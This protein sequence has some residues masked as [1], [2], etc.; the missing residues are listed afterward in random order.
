MN[1]MKQKKISVIPVILIS[2][3][4]LML[5]LSACGIRM[6]LGSN[7]VIR[8]Y[9]EFADG[10]H[11]GMYDPVT[12]D[13]GFPDEEYDATTAMVINWH[14]LPEKNPELDARLAYRKIYPRN[15]V[16]QEAN[17]TSK[18]FWHREELVNRVIL[19]DLEPNSVYEFKVREEGKAFR[20]RTM[21]SSLEER[22]VKIVMTADHQTPGWG[23]TA[24]DNAKMAALQEPDM[25][26]VAGDFVND[27]GQVTAES[28]ENWATY[29]D[30]LYGAGEGYFHIDVEID[31]TLFENMII[32]HVS[33]PGNH[34]TGDEHH[35]RWPADLY[36]P[37]PGYPQFVSANWMEL[38]FH[39]PYSSQGFYSEFRPDHPNIN[40]EQ[41]QE[42]FGHG[43]FGKLS[44]SDYF[45]LIG[46]DNSQN[47]EGEPEKGL[48]DSE[49]NLITDR[50]PWFETHH[51]DVRQDLWLENLLE[52][53]SGVSAAERYT[54]I[55][56]LWHRG[57]FGTVRQNM[58]FKNRPLL[59]YWLP[60]LY[61]NGVKLIKEGHDHNYTRT[62]PM[63]IT[64]EQPEQTDVRKTNYRPATWDLPDGT[65][66]EY[67]DRFY[68]VNTLHG[69][70]GGEIIGW[71]YDN[72]Y[73]TRGEEG[74]IVVGHGGWSAS[75]RDPGNRGGGNAGLWYVDPS[76]GGETYG[77]S[78]S[79]HIH[80]VHLTPDEL[81][82]EMFRPDQLPAFE[83]GEDP[84]AIHRFKWDLSRKG[85][86]VYQPEIMEWVPYGGIAE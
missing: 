61:R 57:L 50:W 16:W 80:A 85:W 19:T 29:L 73:I 65:T 20:F 36:A 54:H 64:T 83:K 22:S 25:F 46:L 12:G 14:R 1:E 3:A 78:A 43:G 4:F 68:T 10:T 5:Q 49:G 39:W 76:K 86:F 6:E 71:E 60:V 74:L 15:S 31:G 42:G 45:L 67:T 2:A 27:E 17:G 55:I 66:P 24:H 58:T 63:V 26:V 33:V 51:S 18:E 77:G 34:E 84:P 82:V 23:Q 8:T 48:R 59:K 81:L 13:K 53:E 56:P 11:R 44:F 28:A 30:I 52:P 37:E 40:P 69:Q 75:R 41:L 35:M 70:D 79:F 9:V 21:P 38:L 72:H 62:V 32:P 47:W 7:E